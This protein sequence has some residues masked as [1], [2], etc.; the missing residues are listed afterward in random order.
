H[1]S[2]IGAFFSLAIHFS[3]TRNS[4][5]YWKKLLA[6]HVPFSQTLF[7]ERRNEG[8]RAIPANEHQRG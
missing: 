2:L 8:V 5:H 4:E 6:G 7:W 3:R 1:P